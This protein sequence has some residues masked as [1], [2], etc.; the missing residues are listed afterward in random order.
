MFCLWNYS[1]DIYAYRFGSINRFMLN[2]IL[3]LTGKLWPLFYVKPKLNSR[4]FSGVLKPYMYECLI[5]EVKKKKKIIL[6]G[7][8]EVEPVSSPVML[9]SV[10]LLFRRWIMGRRI[11]GHTTVWT[12]TGGVRCAMCPGGWRKV[13]RWRPQPADDPE[14]EIKI[15]P[16][17][18]VSWTSEIE[19]FVHFFN[20]KLEF[21]FKNER[22]VLKCEISA[23]LFQVDS[24]KRIIGVVGI[25]RSRSDNN[26]SGLCTRYIM[27]TLN[28][29][30]KTVR[31]TRWI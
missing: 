6:D 28:E 15:G 13:A 5:S 23:P 24:S 29:V 27:W 25:P 1:A 19:R 31:P 21:F 22:L 16:T 20:N 3:A 18:S 8:R 12:R 2:L 11:V 9:P 26:E 7:G 14:G 10:W 4:D 30:G 17:A